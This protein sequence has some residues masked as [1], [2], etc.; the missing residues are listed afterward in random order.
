MLMAQNQI[1]VLNLKIICSCRTVQ[2][3]EEELERVRGQFAQAM[4]KWEEADEDCTDLREQLATEK[5][6]RAQAERECEELSS[7]LEDN[8]E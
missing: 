1:Q 6:L 8:L 3:L 2:H 5:Q 7:L 4:N